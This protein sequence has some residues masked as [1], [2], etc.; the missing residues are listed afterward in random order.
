MTLKRRTRVPNAFPSQ[1]PG[2]LT[3]TVLPRGVAIVAQFAALAGRAFAVVQAAQTLAGPGV[4][5]VWVQH[6]NVVVALTGLTLP[7]RRSRV[8]IVTRRALVTASTCEW[9]NY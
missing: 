3:S 9:R 1:F 5:R 2:L 8:S 4:T 7:A 6:V